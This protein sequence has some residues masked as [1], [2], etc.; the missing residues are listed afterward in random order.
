MKGMDLSILVKKDKVEDLSALLEENCGMEIEDFG[1]Q[2]TGLVNYFQ[3]ENF[4]RDCYGIELSKKYIEVNLNLQRVNIDKYKALRGLINFFIE[5]NLEDYE[6]IK[7]SDILIRH[8]LDREMLSFLK[9]AKERYY[10]EYFNG[11]YSFDLFCKYLEVLCDRGE[12]NKGELIKLWR[13][14]FYT[15]RELI[16]I[17]KSGMITN[18]S[19]NLDFYIIVYNINSRHTH[20]Y[21]D[22]LFEDYLDK[23]GNYQKPLEDYKLIEEFIDCNYI[24]Y[25]VSCKVLP[26][27][28]QYFKNKISKELLIWKNLH[29]YR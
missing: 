17:D 9:K 7:K 3:I 10:D 6:G 28:V 19:S 12:I 4:Y 13:N 2:Y 25:K 21:I 29:F 22:D 27:K 1:C 23:G 11:F 24:R 14:D 8:P 18:L 5:S 16:V 26:D 20:E 15:I